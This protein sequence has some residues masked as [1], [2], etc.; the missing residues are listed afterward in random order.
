VLVVNGN[1][2]AEIAAQVGWRARC[3]AIDGLGADEAQGHA[4]RPIGAV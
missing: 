1:Y 4:A 2:L 3:V